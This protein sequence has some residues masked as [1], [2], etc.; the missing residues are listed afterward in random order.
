MNMAIVNPIPARKPPA[1]TI[2]Q[3][4]VVNRQ[5]QAGTF[6]ETT[7]VFE[8]APTRHNPLGVKGSGE[9]GCCGALPAVVNAVVDALRHRGVHH[10]DMPLSPERVWRAIAAASAR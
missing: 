3:K 1:V 9:A 4:E 5:S 6:Q 7:Y 8:D 10:I 2:A